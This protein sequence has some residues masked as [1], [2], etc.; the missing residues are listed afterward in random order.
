MMS[1]RIILFSLLISLLAGCLHE[2]SRAFDIKNIGKSD[3]DMVTDAHLQEL[4]ILARQL[5]IKLYKLNP[6]E[7]TK[8]P[9]ETTVDKRLGQLFSMPRT[10]R[11]AELGS[12]YGTTAIPL[13]F[14]PDFNGD[15]VFALMV[16]VAGMIHRS[17][18]YQDEFFMLDEIDQQK[19]YHCARNLESVAWQ[20]NQRRDHAG[21]LLLV[22]NSIDNDTGETNLSTERIL[23]K[24][25]SLQDMMAR[26]LA[27][28]NNRAIN[29]VFHGIA[30]TTLLPI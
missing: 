30:S 21:E 13:A 29:K 25:I 14:D 20:L 22:S 5:L 15:R 1:I 9:T 17:Y 26:I 3:I 19:L 11:F 7:L 23:S 6:H 10:I 12:P 24:M 16:G 4:N 27:D 18:N 28:K 2:K 8:A